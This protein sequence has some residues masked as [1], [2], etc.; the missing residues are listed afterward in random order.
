MHFQQLTLFALEVV[1]PAEGRNLVGGA[2]GFRVVLLLIML[3]GLLEE[4]L[5]Y[6]KGMKDDEFWRCEGFN[7]G[8]EWKDLV[9]A[10]LQRFWS[11]FK[12]AVFH[13]L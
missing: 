7:E 10:E 12:I 3:G 11:A 5:R 9:A 13:S 4:G 6:G 8:L 1:V 2:W